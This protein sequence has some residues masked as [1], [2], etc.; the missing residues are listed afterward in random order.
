MDGLNLRDYQLE[1]AGP[2]L[3]SENCMIVAPTGSGKTFVALKICLDHVK[4]KAEEAK[5]IFL[6][7]RV[8]LVQQQYKLFKQY[9]NPNTMFQITGDANSNVPMHKSLQNHQIT[10]MTPQILVNLLG[11][12][13]L[14]IQELTLLIFDECHHAV[15]KDPYS[16]IMKHYLDAK[17]QPTSTLPQIVGL[18]A[19]P[20]FGKAKT[21]AK[22][23]ENIKTLMAILDI[24]LAPVRVKKYISSLR[25]YQTETKDEMKA[26]SRRR[27]DHFCAGIKAVMERI[28]HLIK[29]A[30][31]EY[32]TVLEG[33]LKYDLRASPGSQ[34]YEAW[35]VNLYEA[36]KLIKF[37][38]ATQRFM[39]YA[40]FLREYNT[41]LILND[42]VRSTDARDYLVEKLVL[43]NCA[44]ESVKDELLE[45]HKNICEK[46]FHYFEMDE[47]ENMNPMLEQLYEILRQQ[48]ERQSDSRCIIFVKTRAIAS[49]LLTCLKEQD[50][51]TDLN[52]F[53]EQ[54]I[55]SGRAVDAGMNKTKQ[56]D[57][58]QAFKDGRCKVIVATSVA[59]EGLDI[60]ACNLIIT[61]NYSTNEIG[62]VQRKGRGRAKDSR[63]LMLAY[64]DSGHVRREKENEIR[65]EL[66]KEILDTI[67]SRNSMLLLKD[68]QDIQKKL[69]KT[70]DFEEKV[71]FFKKQRK[72]PDI[73]T[74]YKLICLHCHKQATTSICFRH[75][76][77]KHHVVVDGNF[78]KIALFSQDLNESYEAPPDGG[79]EFIGPIF[80]GN[81]KCRLQWGWRM[82]HSECYVP[83]L[84][85]AHF[86]IHNDKGYRAVKKQWKD[87]PFNSFI[88]E[89]SIDDLSELYEAP[90][91]AIHSN[92]TAMDMENPSHTSSKPP[93]YEEAVGGRSSR[94]LSSSLLPQRHSY[95]E[96]TSLKDVGVNRRSGARILAD[97]QRQ[98]FDKIQRLRL[99]EQESGIQRKDNFNQE[100]LSNL[101]VGTLGETQPNVADESFDSISSQPSGDLENSDEDR[102]SGNTSPKKFI[103]AP[104]FDRT[105]TFPST[106]SPR[107]NENM[108]RHPITS[109]HNNK[110]L[111][112]RDEYISCFQTVSFQYISGDSES[113]TES[114][115]LISD[116]STTESAICVS[117]RKVPASAHNDAGSE[118]NVSD[119]TSTE[120]ESSSGDD[121]LTEN[122]NSANSS[123]F[124]KP[125]AVEPINDND[126]HKLTLVA[127]EPSL[128]SQAELKNSEGNLS[129]SCH[130]PQERSNVAPRDVDDNVATSDVQTSSTNENAMKAPVEIIPKTSDHTV[131]S[132]SDKGKD[133]SS[134]SSSRQSDTTPA[135]NQQNNENEGNS[136]E[137][138]QPSITK[139]VKYFFK[140]MHN[141]GSW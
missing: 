42:H 123:T 99:H 101:Q 65:V 78:R 4:R 89:L 29:R 21:M 46:Q 93:P 15:K 13:L 12:E 124:S 108:H 48:F 14:D 116:T 114:K 113:I 121:D 25:Q 138:N 130:P 10:I 38:E 80:C 52:L 75:I 40:M 98:E 7:P 141:Y 35:C 131:D 55:G 53:P 26:V 45:I 135:S 56:E 81:P 136:N 118:P 134:S 105:T 91:A 104:K 20:G 103:L 1:L 72:K 18:T 119:D 8:P 60:K 54:L 3:R 111:G 16:Q 70:Q 88:R 36:S 120:A 62:R 66:T 37:T 27:G 71:E 34:D 86:V 102:S 6:V 125:L 137:N 50:D 47:K 84:K 31:D 85:I 140:S 32:K 92:E 77:H 132:Q 74:V 57:T 126:R 68:I 64:D 109:K 129:T 43:A 28:H 22:A 58:L 2:G 117:E 90:Q 127:A 139:S 112:E 76:D 30:I 24:S 33:K 44:S 9:F 110:S 23:E 87:V 41:S 39:T 5:V 133:P 69:K 94:P 19:L 61:Y 100:D 128:P 95:D 115:V 96:L 107:N 59:E 67:G 83:V 17:F 82:R 51:L 122:A 63:M 73:K 106:S 49:N 11:D 97:D 79:E